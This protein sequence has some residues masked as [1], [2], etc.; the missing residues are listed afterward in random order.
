MPLEPLQMSDQ[1]MDDEDFPIIGETIVKMNDGGSDLTDRFKYKVHALMGDYDPATVDTDNENTDGNILSAL[2]NFPTRFSF[3]SVGRTNGDEA[4]A[5]AYVGKVKDIVG[6][7]SGDEN[8]SCIVKP[9]GKNFTKI[10]VEAM[11]ESSSMIT[12]IYDQLA[13]LEE[14][15]MRF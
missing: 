10:T 15:V 9:R 3:N 6:S 7:N 1:N 4:F 8:Y 5:D 2:L 11:V 12:N 13:S 14:T